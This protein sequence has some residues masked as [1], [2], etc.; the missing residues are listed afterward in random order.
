MRLA[1]SLRLSA[2]ARAARSSPRKFSFHRVLPSVGT[3]WGGA[4]GG[5][6][7]GASLYMWHAIV[8]GFRV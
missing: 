4:R 5:L 7:G 3:G 2:S 6:I 8:Y 1:L